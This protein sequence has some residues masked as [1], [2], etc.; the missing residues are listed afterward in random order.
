MKKNSIVVGVL[1]LLVSVHLLLCQRF[2]LVDPPVFPDETYFADVS[3]Q[4]NITGIESLSLYTI[5]IGE[6]HVRA[7]SYPPLYQDILS[8][9]MTL[10]GSSIE[11][12]RSLSVVVSV[13]VL[14]SWYLLVYKLSSS[15][16]LTALSS[17][18]ILMYGPFGTASRIARMD[19]IVLLGLIV[20]LLFLYRSKHSYRYIFL[21]G[22]SA[23]VA[24]LSHPSGLLVCGILGLTVLYLSPQKTKLRSFF[25]FI[26]PVLLGT[27]YWFVRYADRFDLFLEQF[28]LQILYKSSRESI[29]TILF[30]S[31]VFWRIRFLYILFFSSL[32]L[33]LGISKKSSQYFFAGSMSWCMILGVFFGVEQWYLLFLPFPLL[34]GIAAN[35]KADKQLFLVI[36][37]VG[38]LVLHSATTIPYI[39]SEKKTNASYANFVQ[40]LVQSIPP[41]ASIVVS[42]VPDPTFDL[43]KR[44]FTNVHA[45]PHV[46]RRGDLTPF[47]HA[48]D[49]LILNYVTNND[50]KEFINANEYKNTTISNSGY[51][52]DVMYLK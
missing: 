19:S 2:L 37:V 12:L 44:G 11:V 39:F 5:G 7:Y 52:A 15:V 1:L 32:F 28:H 23:T 27:L 29:V 30:R 22:I 26:L 25:V 40:E 13:L 21:S 20:G 16:W 14:S 43:W 18:T 17:L 41:G 49:V 46:S 36:S 34:V 45:I 10:F 38:L 31:D 47:I 42:S 6:P 33:F 9:W 51:Q 48:H 4:K 3:L 50:L 8:L 24:W 35:W